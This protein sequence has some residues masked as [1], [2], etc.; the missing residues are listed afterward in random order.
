MKIK[1]LALGLIFVMLFGIFSTYYTFG[2]TKKELQN[3]SSD[4]DSKISS[5]QQEIGEIEEDLSEAMKEVQ[6][7]LMKKQ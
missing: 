4:L 5:T 1:V 7:L 2:A 6:N 3:Q